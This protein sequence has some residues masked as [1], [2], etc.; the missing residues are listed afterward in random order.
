[1]TPYKDINSLLLLLAESLQEILSEQLL[2]LYL[3]GSLTYGDF[4][5]GSSDIVLLAVLDR[6][7]S[8]EQRERIRLMAMSGS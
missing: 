4:D 8:K 2:G 3:T 6:P 5:R 7:L 1:M